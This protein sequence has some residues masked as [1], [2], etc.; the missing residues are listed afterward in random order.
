[1]DGSAILYAGLGAGLGGL[2]GGL[3]AKYIGSKNLKPFINVL[4]IIIGWQG[5]VALYKNMKLPRIFPMDEKSLDAE[6]PA[7][8]ALKENDSSEY[9]KLVKILDEPTRKGNLDQT[10]LNEFRSQFTY[11]IEEKRAVAP[12]ELLRKHNALTSESFRIL[13]VKNPEICTAQ[14]NGRAFAILTDILGENYGLKEQKLMAQLFSVKT[15]AR[16]AN[17]D[18]GEQFY[19]EILMKNV[20][21]LGIKTLDPK[22]GEVDMVYS[23]HQLVCQLFEK[24]M[25]AVNLLDDDGV[26]NVAAYISNQTL[27]K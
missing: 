20:K 14:A 1:V 25:S 10:H 17:V 15:I 21:D 27:N 7:F 22:D 5:T 13:R 4:P 6:N 26:L 24:S 19:T 18:L 2:I 9:K 12:P 23:E 8:K 16:D 11:L 3:L